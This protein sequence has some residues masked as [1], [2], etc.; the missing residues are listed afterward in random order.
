MKSDVPDPRDAAR[1]K[2]SKLLGRHALCDHCLGRLFS[3][4]P[5]LASYEPSGRR[6]RR[7]LEAVAD[8][9][10]RPVLCLPRTL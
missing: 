2:A 8:Q 3:R 10:L 9:P 6:L 7:S 4:G 1:S 5:G